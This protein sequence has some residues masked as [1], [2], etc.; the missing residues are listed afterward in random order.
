MKDTTATRLIADFTKATIE[1]GRQWG[2][3]FKMLWKIT[4]SQV[5]YFQINIIQQGAHT[6]NWDED[7]E[8]SESQPLTFAERTTKKCSLERREW[9]P[10]WM[11][12]VQNAKKSNKT[13]WC[14][15]VQT[16]KQ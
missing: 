14:I 10:K 4:V 9:K 12:R 8:N 2:N 11:N 5:F 16:T 3:N 1:F 15:S 13:G 6:Q 7:S